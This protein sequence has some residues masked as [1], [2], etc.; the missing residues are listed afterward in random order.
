MSVATEHY[1]IRDVEVH[2]GISINIREAGAFS[3]L[4]V[5]RLIV[6]QSHPGHWRAVRHVGSGAFK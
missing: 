4:D 6:V 3:A 2:V 1:H 5:D